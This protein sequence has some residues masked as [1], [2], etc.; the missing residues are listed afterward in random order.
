VF[1]NEELDKILEGKR[2]E[3]CFALS[4]QVPVGTEVNHGNIPVRTDDV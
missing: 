3:Y 4:Q 2:A 1:T